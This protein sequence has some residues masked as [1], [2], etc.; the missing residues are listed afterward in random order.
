V[1][2]RSLIQKMGFGLV[3]FPALFKSSVPTTEGGSVLF[4]LPQSFGAKGDGKT[5]DS[6]A[7]NTAIDH[8]YE[9]GGGVVYVRS[10]TYLCGTVI[11]KSR[12][13]LY[14]EAGAIL[15]GSKDVNQYTPQHGPSAT[16]DTGAKH[17]L[18]A[19]DV[20]DVTIMGPGLIDGQGKSFWVPSD[21]KQVALEDRWQDVAT[22]Y[23]KPLPRVSPMIELANCRRLR[24][25]DIRIENAS[26]WTMRLNNCSN[27]VVDGISIKNPVYGIN[28]DGIDVTNC[29]DVRIANCSIDT[30]D[31]AICLKSEKAYGD[32]V[33]ACRNI[34]VT[35]C[36]MSGCCN[37]FKFGTGTAGAFE[38]ITFSN[39]VIYNDDVDLNARIISGICLE[40]VDGGSVEGVVIVGI[41]MQRTRTPIFLRLGNRTP[42]SN[43]QAGTLR[44][45]TISDIL[46]TGAVA[47]SSIVGIPGYDIED[48]TLANVRI[49]TMEETQAAWL[50]RT[51]PEQIKSYPESRMFGRLPAWGLYC[52]H[53][54]GLRLR[55][56]SLSSPAPQATPVLVCDDVKQVEISGLRAIC[57]S[58]SASSIEFQNVQGAW[59]RDTQAIAGSPSLL[60]ASGSSSTNVLIT[61]CDLRGV[62]EAV[63]R[64]ADCPPTSIRASFNIES[65]PSVGASSP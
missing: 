15:L 34:T 6:D 13:T 46:A 20:E 27:V 5:L 2:R 65:Q 63:T 25:E 12:V 55:D 18:F 57:P 19:R 32:S 62:H 28:V 53:V 49:E 52:R 3:G 14:L 9:A 1:N 23:W 42:R 16:G 48:V 17:L 10:G 24:I 58:Q 36:T 60:H 8:A 44:C 21:R 38:N 29:S 11:L 7:I 31:D 41:R 50:S 59:I 26:G 30:A 40:M 35:N 22:L 45:V 43:G 37:G 51:I 56:L 4:Y 61:S 39:S 33:P 64:S 47:T 54:N